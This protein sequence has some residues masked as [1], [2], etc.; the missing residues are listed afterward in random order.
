MANA[1]IYLGDRHLKFL[2]KLIMITGKRFNS[3]GETC[4]FFLPLLYHQSLRSY[5]NIES[6]LF[7]RKKITAILPI[8]IVKYFENLIYTVNR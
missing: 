6:L 7:H 3:Y 1:P 8:S 5:L 4:S 2:T